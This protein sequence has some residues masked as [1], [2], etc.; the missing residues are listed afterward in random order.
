[1]LSWGR[2]HIRHLWNCSLLCGGNRLIFFLVFSY[3][4]SIS[5]LKLLELNLITQIQFL[6]L[7]ESLKFHTCTHW[8]L[9]QICSKS[10]QSSFCW[11]HSGL[12]KTFFDREQRLAG[13]PSSSSQGIVTTISIF[14]FWIQAMPIEQLFK[15]K[16]TLQDGF[17]KT[18]FFNLHEKTF[19]EC[20]LLF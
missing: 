4:H 12:R 8:I 11:S 5:P 3:F 15:Y 1:V 20:A 14:M 2:N 16:K 9:Y 7:I 18:Y 19:G 10:S 6:H 13:G 17:K